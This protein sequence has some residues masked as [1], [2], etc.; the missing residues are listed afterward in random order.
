MPAIANVMI[1]AYFEIIVEIMNELNPKKRAMTR[2]NV[3]LAR[4]FAS[5][6]R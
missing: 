3:L 1:G 2:G 5:A 6:N 4:I